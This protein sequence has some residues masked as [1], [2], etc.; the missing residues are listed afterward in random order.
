MR[1][2]QST[3]LRDAHPFPFSPFLEKDYFLIKKTKQN[4]TM[5]PLNYLTIE[6]T[7]FNS[8]WGCLMKILRLQERNFSVQRWSSRQ[9]LATEMAK[10]VAGNNRED[11]GVPPLHGVEWNDGQWL[12]EILGTHRERYCTGDIAFQTGRYHW[13]SQIPFPIIIIIVIYSFFKAQIK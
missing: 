6:D 13:L 7:W 5:K 12:K 10:T 4:C 2:D 8:S 9:R 1:N 11:W 3:T